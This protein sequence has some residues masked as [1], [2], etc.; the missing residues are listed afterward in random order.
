ML[1]SSLQVGPRFCLFQLLSGHQEQIVEISICLM[2]Y[3]MEAVLS[4][5]DTE[6][7]GCGSAMPR[8]GMGMW[9]HRE[10]LFI[11]R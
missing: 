9:I 4:C 5:E 6:R 2:V 8:T 7:L 11:M 3:R 10:R 1:A